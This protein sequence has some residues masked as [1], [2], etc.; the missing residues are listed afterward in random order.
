MPVVML[1]RHG[2]ASPDLDDYD[3][4]S[5]LGRQQARVVGAALAE[6]RLRDPLVATGTL[7]RQVDTASEALDAMKLDVTPSVDERWNEYDH[8]PILDE[9]HDGSAPVTGIQDVLDGGLERWAAD[10]SSSY[11]QWA[12]GIL[13]AYREF[14][15]SVP[16]GRDGVVFTSGGV[17]GVIA[18]HLVGA[19]VPGF[20][21]F[22]RVTVNASI[23]MTTGSAMVTFNEHGHLGHRSEGL[24][25]YR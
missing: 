14:V 25:T 10:P 15:A 17:I 20:V 22:N 23:T 9:Y 5:D 19:P 21:R 18:A 2:Q 1:V 24:V 16:S 6:R 8:G 4:L 3:H 13:D 11:P 7:S 12:G